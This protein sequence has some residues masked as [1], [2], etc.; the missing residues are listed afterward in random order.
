MKTAKHREEAFRADLALLLERHDA[1]LCVTDDGKP[2]GLHNGICEITMQSKWDDD[3]NE[4]AEYTS[5]RL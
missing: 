1:E 5:F 4:V 3:G 2:Y